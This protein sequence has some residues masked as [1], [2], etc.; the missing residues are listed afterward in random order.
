MI[1][2]G[3]TGSP[4]PGPSVNPLDLGLRPAQARDEAF[5]RR[6][7]DAGR[8]WEFDP[9]RHD[10]ELHAK[11]L[12]QQFEAQHADYF[13]RFTLAQYAV[14]EWCGQPVGRLYADFRDAEIRL[15]DLMILPAFRG[16]GIGALIVRGLCAQA[17]VERKPVTL[18]VHPLNPARRLYQR[19]GFATREARTGPF[20][21]MV[22]RDRATTPA[23]I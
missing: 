20:L 9:L 11:V 1:G 5:L 7:H 6:V 15:L 2:A 19:L 14:V 12:A 3:G 23:A 18:Q 17:S 16:R 22:W 8:A 13:N 21:E 4:A 10:R